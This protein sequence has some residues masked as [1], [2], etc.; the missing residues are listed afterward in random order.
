MLIT[1]RYCNK[2]IF[3]CRS[4]LRKDHCDFV[5]KCRTL[6][7]YCRVHRIICGMD[8]QCENFPPLKD[9]FNDDR[10]KFFLSCETNLSH[11]LHPLVPSRLPR[12]EHFRL[13]SIHSARRLKSFFPHFCLMCNERSSS[14]IWLFFSGLL[15]CPLL[16]FKMP[17]RCFSL[18][19]LICCS[20]SYLCYV[21]YMPV[22]IVWFSLLSN[23]GLLFSTLLYS[24][25]TLIARIFFDGGEKSW[26]SAAYLY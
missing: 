9:K 25:P 19:Y 24:R 13:P 4:R 16:Q 22:R 3:V 12:T 23:I 18:T 6:S 10:I 8:C 15:Q 1:L 20:K 17:F 14:T 21:A 5:N 26:I 7:T 2:L 11:P